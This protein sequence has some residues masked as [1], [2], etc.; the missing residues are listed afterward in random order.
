MPKHP[1]LIR[2]G[3]RY[4]LRAKVPDELRAIL[5]KREIWRSLET[6]DHKQA[7]DRV[8]VA[9]VEVDAEFAAARRK[10][11][12]RSATAI[13]AQTDA[14]L[15][16]LVLDWFGDRQRVALGR[17]DTPSSDTVDRDEVIATL[18]EDEARLADRIEAEDMRS[19]QHLAHKLLSERSIVL[20]EP[21][22]RQY[23]LV[24][25]L[26]HRAL[27]EETRRALG[28]YDGRLEETRHELFRGA[29]GA[30]DG[31]PAPAAARG[32]HLTLGQL[33]ERFQ[34][35]PSRARLRPRTRE[36]YGLVFRIVE[37]SLGSK[38]PRIKSRA[39][40][41]AA[42]VKFWFSCPATPEFGFQ[43]WRSQK[44]RSRIAPRNCRGCI[45]RPSTTI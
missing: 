21:D 35:D 7:L 11:A 31:L 14:E 38:H 36:A 19:A 5:G 2:R 24:V 40:T 37:E 45:P 27:L 17:F 26:V 39:K 34:S 44:Q 30:P 13:D 6:A 20:G 33:I 32:L 3:S 23:W 28:R 18:R 9:S 16:Q 41:A 12:G 29:T 10:L 1:R 22:G 43:A 8:R 42:S 25:R 15:H 4:S